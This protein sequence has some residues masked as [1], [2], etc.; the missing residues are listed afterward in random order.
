VADIPL[1]DL[2]SQRRRLGGRVEAAIARVLEHGSF[3]LGPEVAELE[4]RLASYVG[5]AHTVTCSSGTDALLMAFMA[6]GVGP[7]DAVVL[8]S[9]TFAATAEPVVLAGAVP[10]FA[11]VLPD[12]FD[13]DAKSLELAVDAAT[14][15][16][17]RAAVVVT[18]DLYGQPA[19]YDAIA[20]VCEER[21]LL[22]VADAAQ[23]FGGA[24]RDQRVGRLADITTTSFFPS[25]PLGCYGDG[26]AIFT[27][28]ADVAERLRS[29]RVHGRGTSKY[30]NV[31]LG[32]N[33]RLDTLQAAILLEKLQLV[34]EERDAR[35]RV[36][37]AYNERLPSPVSVPAVRADAT[38][39][40]AHYTVRVDHRDE[41]AA[42][43]AAQGVSTGVYY[44]TPLHRQP[45]YAEYPR[46]TEDL[47]ASD[48]LAATVLSLPMHAY[49]D[50]VSQDRVIEAVTD[51]VAGRPWPTGGTRGSGR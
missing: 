6:H 13:L 46:A 29:V 22:L 41:M 45:R 15:S 10:V 26:G 33:A 4:E 2:A 40:W 43:L 39:A 9:F 11:D 37:G 47:G 42:A 30:D 51:A 16:G 49:L 31:R 44:P 34:D 14:S 27:D 38:S 20:A 8:P 17:L 28:D 1:V 3:I 32:L 21:G 19:D 36:A 48:A 24:W 50:E 35:T 12:T 25:K 18:V 7:G 5:I 23:S